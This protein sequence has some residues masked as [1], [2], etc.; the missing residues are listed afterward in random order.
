MPMPDTETIELRTDT[1]EQLI[2][3][4]HNPHKFNEHKPPM[5][6][7]RRMA[8][9]SRIQRQISRPNAVALSG[10]P[11]AGKSYVAEKLGDVYDAAVVSMGDAIREQYQDEHGEVTDSTD[12]GNFA[13]QWRADD[14]EG[15]PEKVVEIAD[16]KFRQLDNDL[17]IIDGVRSTTDYE[18][19]KYYFD[20]FYL[21]EVE[22]EFY[23][24]LS[25]IQE[26]DREGEA[27]FTAVDLAERDERER[28]ELGFGEL[29]EYSCPDFTV[30]NGKGSESLINQ[31]SELVENH[32][33]FE[34]MDGRPLGLDDNLER[35]RRA[36]KDKPS[37]PLDEQFY[38]D[39]NRGT[40]ASK[41]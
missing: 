31:L 13:A 3:L 27:A 25:R 28:E 10:L 21:L 12:L 26:R 30:N 33:Q 9:I 35:I 4:L 11:G 14:P 17:I 2:E 5:T 32:F 7:D 40:S 41:M 8:V 39:V 19:L 36:N 34:I 6:K 23:H 18:V 16:H 29:C 1:I 22:A 37:K 24:R 15:I 20:D 38:P